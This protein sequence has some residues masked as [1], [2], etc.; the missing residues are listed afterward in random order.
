LREQEAPSR[1]EL[2]GQPALALGRAVAVAEARAAATSIPHS[3]FFPFRMLTTVAMIASPWDHGRMCLGGVNLLPADSNTDT[4]PCAE[5]LAMNGTGNRRSARF[6]AGSAL[7]N[8]L[9]I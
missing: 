1:G 6:I 5:I 4:S 7:T 8:T 3:H 2:F 9:A